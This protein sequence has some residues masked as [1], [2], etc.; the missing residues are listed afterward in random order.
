MDLQNISKRVQDA[1]GRGPQVVT[2]AAGQI[3]GELA[4]RVG[5][6]AAPVAAWRK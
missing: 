6:L 4:V 3:I 5:S 1:D 2:E